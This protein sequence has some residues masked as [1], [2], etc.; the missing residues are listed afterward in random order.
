MPTHG[1]Y[2][3]VA[4]TQVW[5]LH[6]SGS[7]PICPPDVFTQ[8]PAAGAADVD[9]EELELEAHAASSCHPRLQCARERSQGS[10][11]NDECGIAGVVCSHG[12][13]L[14]GGMLEMPAPERF[15]YY[16]LLMVQVLQ[17]A[18]VDIMFLD[19]GCTY[20]RHWQLYLAEGPAPGAIKVPWWHARGHGPSCY[21]KNSGL[22]LQGAAPA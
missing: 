11:I 15:L 8:Q 4:S 21:V 1:R 12:L 16:D 3:G 13:P 14:H 2:L 22:Y 18:D 9:D 6:A 19:T 20:A 17:Q 10:S 7:L 5:Q